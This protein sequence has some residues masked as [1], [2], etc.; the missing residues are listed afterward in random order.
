MAKKITCSNCP[1]RD[2]EVESYCPQYCS[3]MADFVDKIRTKA[4]DEYKK[5]RT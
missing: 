3:D 2:V 5:N 1:L 4:I